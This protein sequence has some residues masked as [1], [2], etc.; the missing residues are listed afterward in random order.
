MCIIETFNAMCR[1]RQVQMCIDQTDTELRVMI[2]GRQFRSIPKKSPRAYNLA[3]EIG[4]TQMGRIVGRP[5]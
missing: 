3:V 5:S 1:E 2:E 4:M